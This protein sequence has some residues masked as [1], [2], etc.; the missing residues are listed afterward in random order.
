M[1][2]GRCSS[3]SLLFTA[4][5]AMLSSV[6]WLTGAFGSTAVA[7]GAGD[8]AYS[9]S[10]GF[11]GFSDDYD[12]YLEEGGSIN[13]G[14]NDEATP[15]PVAGE[16]EASM[17]PQ[18]RR[19]PT[20]SV[21]AAVPECPANT[22][23]GQE[24]WAP[25]S[26]IF[27]FMESEI[28]TGFQ[29]YDNFWEVPV[30]ICDVHWW[31][32]E[33]D[34]EFFEDCE[35]DVTFDIRFY[36]DDSGQP[37]TLYFEQTGLTPAETDTGLIYYY[38]Q[39][40]PIEL[41]YYEVD[42][43]EC[44]TGLPNGWISIVADED[45]QQPTCVFGM[46]PS[47]D[48]DGICYGW[49]GEVFESRDFDLSFC[50]T[51][52]TPTPEPTDTPTETPTLTPTESPT[53]TSTPTDT[54]T[55]TPTSTPTRTPTRTPTGTS[56]PT[57]SPTMSPTRTPTLTPTLSPTL[58]PTETPTST[59]TET[60]SATPTETP[61]IMPTAPPT[62]SV[63][64]IYAHEIIFDP[65]A[66]SPGQIV[67]ITVPVHNEGWVDVDYTEVYFGYE[68]TPL[69][70]TD[71]PN[72]MLIGNP[73]QLNDIEVGETE[74]AV[75]QWDTTGLDAISHRVYVFTYNTIPE[76]CIYELTVTDYIVPV[77][78]Y[79]FTTHAQNNRV[80]LS[81]TTGTEI[82]NTGFLVY[83]SEQFGGSYERISEQMIPGA[84][85]SFQKHDYSATDINVKNGIPYFYKLAMVDHQ[86]RKSWSEVVSA[87]PHRSAVDVQ[88]NTFSDRKLYS[89]DQVMKLSGVLM[90]NHDDALVDIRIVLLVNSVYAGDIVPPTRVK[91]DSDARCAF[92]LMNYSWTGHEP[93]GDY[94]IA[95]VM[96][97][98]DEGELIHADVTDFHYY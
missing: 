92:D 8:D 86:N 51:G 84:G 65:E 5:F 10:V 16:A 26:A 82:N 78:L 9:E 50:L 30:D 20:P 58:S 18:F 87:V 93:K 25:G 89:Q 13:M 41:K 38:Y 77:E 69:D 19:S 44:C 27:D 68:L 79:S 42:L 29:A 35:K 45:P 43:P 23:F 57:F 4:V 15:T 21:T 2:A 66:A 75:T 22:L 60:S 34:Y 12:F 98:A 61:T 6:V 71:D 67:T 31:G 46:G 73:V 11:N 52:A 17:T 55:L 56:S 62:C 59:P 40:I 28:T 1:K 7:D 64:K 32:F 80:I 53:L 81:W 47:S 74:N 83:R 36:E 48:G 95:A 70:P 37:G 97:D 85:T 96:N 63:L 91:V 76:E 39:E 72:L 88:F 14:D 54:P 24:P 49:F 90:N 94:I 3:W 33:W